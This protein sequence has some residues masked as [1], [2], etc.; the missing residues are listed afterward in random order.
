MA[1]R[2]K[3][4]LG[5]GSIHLVD[6]DGLRTGL[7]DS[8]AMVQTPGSYRWSP[9]RDFL[10]DEAALPLVPPKPPEDA[11]SPDPADPPPGDRVAHPLMG[12]PPPMQVLADDPVF[13][14][15]ADAGRKPTD[16][17]RLPIIGL[18]PLDD[19]DDEPASPGW[20]SGAIEDYGVEAVPHPQWGDRIRERLLAAAAA[21]GTLLGRTLDRLRA[22]L[23]RPRPPVPPAAPAASSAAP[24]SPPEPLEPPP[25]TSDL[26]VLHF[27]DPPEPREV[28]DLYAGGD[29]EGVGLFQTVWHWT[30]RWVVIAGLAA[31]GILVVLTGKTWLPT[32]ARLGETMVAAIHAR[33]RPPVETEE[34]TRALRAATQQLPHLAPDTIRL[35]LSRSPGG[36]LDPPK[37]FQLASDAADRGRSVLTAG[38]AKELKALQRELVRTLRPAERERVREYDRAR[39]RRTVFAF[40]N[41]RALDLCARGARALPPRSRERLQLL[42]GKAISV[43]VLRPAEVAP[44]DVP[45]R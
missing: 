36:V 16:A 14:P 32:A 39:S 38:E 37:V 9:L 1:Q 35:L 22:R 28:E 3:L 24:P 26:P 30:K 31:G 27:A 17:D 25:P 23:D 18:K 42:L 6:Q 33:L 43:G 29:E 21:F 41:R 20:G 8:N 44:W 4:R 2:Y 45:A 13:A 40:E 15:D 7:G 10:A 12:E 5:D 11:V 19:R 34:Q